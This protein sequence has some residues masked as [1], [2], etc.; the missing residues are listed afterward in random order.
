MCSS[1]LE[2]SK[3][4]LYT[5]T[6][7]IVNGIPWKRIRC[8]TDWE[9]AQTVYISNGYSCRPDDL[10]NHEEIVVKILGAFVQSSRKSVS[11]A[12]L[13]THTHEIVLYPVRLNSSMYFFWINP[14]LLSTCLFSFIRPE[15]AVSQIY[16]VHLKWWRTFWNTLYTNCNG[17]AWINKVFP[18]LRSVQRGQLISARRWYCTT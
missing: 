14:V 15:L 4:R 17:A 2:H 5:C 1:I 12:R 7:C 16:R 8:S 13:E 18:R 9:N 11:R 6:A 3:T 10:Y